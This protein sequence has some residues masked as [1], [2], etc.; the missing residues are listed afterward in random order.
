LDEK[1]QEKGTISEK[2]GQPEE[3]DKKEETKH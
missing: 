2:G 3:K 1:A